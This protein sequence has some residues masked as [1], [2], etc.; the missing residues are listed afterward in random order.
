M[1]K[2][3]FFSHLVEFESVY[4]ALGRMNLSEKEKRHLIDIADSSLHHVVMDAILSELSEE[5]K[6]VFLGHVAIEDHR[7]IWEF[8]NK[9][10]DHIEEKIKTAADGLKKELHEDIKRRGHG[11]NNSPDD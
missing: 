11:V 7:Q 9:K 6:K 5:D 1:Q 8:L 2:K 4:V 10:I 3:H